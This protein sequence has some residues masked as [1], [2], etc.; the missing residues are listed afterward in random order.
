[1]TGHYQTAAHASRP[2]LYRE[3]SAFLM[4]ALYQRHMLYGWAVALCVIL[5]PTLLISAWPVEKVEPISPEPA[6]RDTVK[7]DWNDRPIKIVYDDPGGTAGGVKPPLKEG[8]IGSII[9]RVIIVDDEIVID[10]EAV[11]GSGGSIEDGLEVDDDFGFGDGGGGTVYVPDSTE[12][13]FNSAELDRPPVMIAMNQPEYPP[14]AK[15]AEVAGKVL[16]HVLV[17]TRGHVSDV[18]IE[19]ESNPNFDCARH[20]IFAAHEDEHHAHNTV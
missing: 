1:M 3:T 17:D 16:L 11:F 19:N 13:Q 14:L 6:K 5:I 18:R 10:D 8:T 2:T 4:K 15:R 7:V 9:D 20:D 12:Y